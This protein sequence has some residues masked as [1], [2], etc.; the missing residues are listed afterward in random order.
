MEKDDQSSVLDPAPAEADQQPIPAQPT[1]PARTTSTTTTPT[2]SERLRTFQDSALHF[3]SNASNE[4]LGAC[5]VGLAASTYLVLGRL[6][7]VLIG[8]VGG[9][10]LHATW[11]GQIGSGADGEAQEKQQRRRRELGIEVTK[12]AL[13]WRDAKKKD[14]QAE[15]SEADDALD[16]TSTDV[17]ADFQPETRA[18]LNDFTDAVI[19]DY[20]KWWFSPLLPKEQ[21]FPL[22]CRQTLSQFILTFSN[23]LSRKRTADPVLDFMAN[24]TSIM[25]VFLQELGTALKASQN[26]DPATAIRTYLQYQPESNLANVINTSQQERKLDIVAE[27]ILQNFLDKSSHDCPP[28]KAF[29]RA[30]L[31]GLILQPTID[32][33]SKPEWINGWIVYL[34][35]DG[36]PEL[37]NVIDAGVE[38][39][40]A[41]GAKVPTKATSNEGKKHQRRV[42]RAEEAMQQAMQEAERM[43]AMIAED[44]ARRKRESNLAE[45]VDTLSTANTDGPGLATPTSSDSDRNQSER[46]STRPTRT[47]FIFDSEGNAIQS[48]SASPSRNQGLFL[49]GAM[50]SVEAPIDMLHPETSMGISAT[51]GAGDELRRLSRTCIF[52]HMGD[53]DDRAALRKEPKDDMYMIQIEPASSK[54]PGW[55]VTRAYTDFT[56]IHPTLLTIAKI[57]GV[58]EFSQQYPELPSWKGVAR[59]S[60]RASLEYYLR[61][62]LKYE[63]LAESD[64]MKKFLDKEVGISKAPTQTKN[65]FVQSGAALENVGKGFVNVLGQGGKG[66]AGGGKAVLGG[67]QGAFG[68]ITSG[69]KKPATPSRPIYTTRTNTGSSAGLSRLSQDIPR[70]SMEISDARSEPRP[71]KSTSTTSLNHRSGP[72]SRA[73]SPPRLLDLS[74]LP[75]PPDAMSDEYV[76]VKPMTLETPVRE[77][78][79]ALLAAPSSPDSVHRSTTGPRQSTEDLSHA[80]PS[81]IARRKTRTNHAPINEE[82]TRVTIDLMFAIIT[83]LYSL[84]SAWTIRLS[85]L[86]AAKTYLLRPQNPQL[87]SIRLLL[88]ES[89]L[90]ANF[91][92]AGMATHIR[93]LRENSVPTEEERAKWPAELTA[94]EKEALRIK[95]RKLL[96]ERGMPQALTSVMGAAASGEALGRVFD[97][98]QIEEVAR[99]LIFALTLQAIRATTQ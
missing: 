31:S 42:S 78:S 45:S 67:V 50:E 35:E 6:G 69:I 73:S 80:R 75:P 60:F 10:V 1:S 92:D 27:D 88:Q 77:T 86:S 15:T 16:L 61:D 85:L 13:D 70:K 94:D 59:R 21:S 4:T 38:N 90:D 32:M 98:L 14:R 84:S 49:D 64:T 48:A 11:E 91:S 99:G 46:F 55:M 57:S 30:V 39:M 65:V 24:S 9:I 8:A 93:K 12:R 58:P 47:S 81:P 68:T 20:V 52:L 41:M 5:A 89:V 40:N 23:R 34:L 54:F 87:E 44:E 18:A 33:C 29:L 28:V 56:K 26:Q 63:R 82:E 2:T 53:G 43:N 22:A 95:A 51:D 3:L 37:I 25:I 36:E 17:Y 71:P 79:P 62:A 66:I 83:E 96:V 7:L 76:P 72:S 19:R 74:N 97:C